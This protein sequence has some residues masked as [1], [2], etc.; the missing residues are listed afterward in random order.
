M[1]GRLWVR[2]CERVGTVA[3]KCMY[4]FCH[5]IHSTDTIYQT[6]MPNNCYSTFSIYLFIIYSTNK[7]LSFPILITWLPPLMIQ[8]PSFLA[9]FWKRKI[10]IYT[11]THTWH[12]EK[13]FVY[14]AMF[15]RR[16]QP[17]FFLK[18]VFQNKI[19]SSW[20]CTTLAL[21]PHVKKVTHFFAINPSL[22]TFNNSFH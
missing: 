16:M 2:T 18:K 10:Y 21:G 4:L 20:F 13:D 1:I 6:H 22:L 19:Y 14:N 7:N 8:I 3:W 15:K 17:P 5:I 11:H 9:L 12:K